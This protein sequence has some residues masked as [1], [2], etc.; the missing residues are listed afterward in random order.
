M[1]VGRDGADTAKSVGM[2]MQAGLQL[3]KAQE[4]CQD[5][6]RREHV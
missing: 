1:V 4:Q 6:T 5:Q 2:S 3:S